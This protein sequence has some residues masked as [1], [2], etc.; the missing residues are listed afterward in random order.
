[1][2]DDVDYLR[3]VGVSFYQDAIAR[4]E[5]GQ[6][7]RFVHEP[8]N[9][10]DAMALRIV[11]RLGETIGYAPRKSWIHHTIH[12]QGRGVSAVIH[13]IGYSRARL[14][15]V[16]LSMAICDDEVERASYYPDRPAP[17]TP[18]GGFRYWVNSPTDVARLVAAQR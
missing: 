12:Q 9:P 10:H 8:D 16:M 11:S 3:V 1:M 6:P 5:P 15:G 18:S 2:D 14:L 7:V 4:C 17:E 13:S